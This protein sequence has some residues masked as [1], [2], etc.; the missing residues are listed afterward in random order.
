LKYQQKIL[1][2]VFSDYEADQDNNDSTDIPMIAFSRQGTDDKFT[3]GF[4]NNKLEFKSS[5]SADRIT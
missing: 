5:Y 4:N 2:I 1:V 3:M